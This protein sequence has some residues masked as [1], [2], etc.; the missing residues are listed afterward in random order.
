LSSMPQKGGVWISGFSRAHSV[1][2]DHGGPHRTLDLKAAAARLAR[3]AL[4]RISARAQYP[5]S[6]DVLHRRLPGAAST[7][8]SNL[9]ENVGLDGC[10]H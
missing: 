6:H 7:S 5:F 4:W 2:R 3:P 1:T 10:E 8:R 9:S